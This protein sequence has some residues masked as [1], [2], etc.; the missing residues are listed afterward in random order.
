LGVLQARFVQLGWVLGKAL[1]LDVHYVAGGDD[2][3][4]A[5]A[6]LIATAPDVVFAIGSAAL[7]AV[8][9][10]TRS[11][12]VVFAEITDPVSLGLVASLA[13]PGGNATGFM[14]FASSM[15]AKWLELLKQVAPNVTRAAAIFNPDTAAYE[16]Y[17]R[18]LE[19]GGP[20][21]GV[22][23]TRMPVRNDS[24]IGNAI[25]E[26]A[27]KP[28]G[29]LVV[30][31]DVFNAV[32]SVAIVNE[33]ARAQ[34]P[35]IYWRR[36]IV[37]EQGGLICYSIDERSEMRLAASYID[38]IL[39]GEKPADLPVQRPTKFEL[40]INLKTAKALGLTIPPSLLVRADEVIE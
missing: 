20:S 31:P 5:A 17:V 39:K 40:V 25:A 24:E 11:L 2:F 12:P 34:I 10:K 32:H 1:D 26:F 33:V 28:S 19:A 8:Q 22:S 21:L 18:S 9:E 4:A 13:H 14:T 3:R 27:R 6:N 30:I 37:A 15:G 23:L 36:S 7:V 38:R 35:A 16:G 29:G